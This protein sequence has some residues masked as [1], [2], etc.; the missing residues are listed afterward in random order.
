MI[1]PK[2]LKT[3]WTLPLQSPHKRWWLLTRSEN[4]R[5]GIRMTKWVTLVANLI[6]FS[7]S[8]NVYSLENYSLTSLTA[9][10]GWYLFTKTTWMAYWLTTWDSVKQSRQLRFSATCGKVGVSGTSLTWSLLRKAQYRTGCV[11]LNDGRPSSGQSTWSQRKS[12]ELKFCRIR[13]NGASSIFVWPPT[14]H[15]SVYRNCASILGIS[16]SSMKPTNWKMRSHRRCRSPAFCHPSAA[17][18]W[19]AHLWWTTLV[20]F[21]ACW[22]SSC[23]SFLHPSRI[24]TIGST[25]T[26]AKIKRMLRWTNSRKCWSYSAY[27]GW[28]VL[29]CWDGRRLI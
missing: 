8:P 24:S 18:C 1:R 22:I 28:C 16:L 29:S 7:G 10:S 12:I 23:P 4:Q 14:K 20:N 15:L 6:I 2:E 9:S 11:N 26:R 25:S 27:I 17:S 13:W 3:T 5:R 21:G 19:L